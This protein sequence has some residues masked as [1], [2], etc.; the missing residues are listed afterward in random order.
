M[1]MIKDL[2]KELRRKKVFKYRR[3]AL[4]SA[5]NYKEEKGV[6]DEQAIERGVTTAEILKEFNE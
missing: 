1:S 3:E 5:L 2:D 6:T 4:Q